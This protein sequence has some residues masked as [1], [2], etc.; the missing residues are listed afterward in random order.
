MMEGEREMMEGERDDGGRER[1]D[2][3]R[4]R[5]DRG[6]EIYKETQR[7]TKKRNGERRSKKKRDTETDKHRQ[8]HSQT[9]VGEK[10]TDLCLFWSV[11]CEIEYV[12]L[13]TKVLN[14]NLETVWPAGGREK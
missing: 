13:L 1:D 4:E 14:H 3:G 8:K 7:L 2:G 6:R 9:D 10:R 11:S 12:L 5:D